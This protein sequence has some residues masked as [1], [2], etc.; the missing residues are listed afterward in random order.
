MR[1]P[2]LAY[3]V[4]DDPITSVITELI[5]RRD[6]NC[7]QVQQYGNGQ[8]AYDQ[9]RAVL[10]DEA[11]IPDVI[12]LDLNMPH[13]DGW[14]FLDAFAGLHIPKPVCVFVLTSSIHPNDIAK[15]R[16]YKQVRGYFSKPLDAASLVRMRQLLQE[17]YEAEPVQ[18]SA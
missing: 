2:K 9:L 6:L 7:G 3:V 5:V 1:T 13:M 16:Y 17:C 15:S 18:A 4:E 11:C 14:E 12:L 8:Q 10:N